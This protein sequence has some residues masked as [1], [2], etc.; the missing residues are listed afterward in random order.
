MKAI[1]EY[2]RKYETIGILV[3]SPGRISLDYVEDIRPSGLTK[4]NGHMLHE[5]TYVGRTASA[6]IRRAIEF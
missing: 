2:G 1:L 3:Y 5:N 4:H 6:R